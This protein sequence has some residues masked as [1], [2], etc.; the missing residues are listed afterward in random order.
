MIFFRK[1]VLF[2]LA[3]FSIASVFA[4][5]PNQS[6]KIVPPIFEHDDFMQLDFY[7]S[8]NK[9][10]VNDSETAI[11]IAVAIWSAVYGK[12]KIEKQKPYTAIEHEGFWYVNGSLPKGYEGGVAHIKI[13][14]KDGAVM[15]Y[16]HTK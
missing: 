10:F 1:T 3:L 7:T 4:D 14:K 5:E 9:D 15:G 6:K 12:D 2:F 13:R 16:I 11:Q 8:D